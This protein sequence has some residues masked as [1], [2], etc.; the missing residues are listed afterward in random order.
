MAPEIETHSKSTDPDNSESPLSTRDSLKKRYLYKIFANIVGL[1]SNLVVASIVP[2]SLGPKS[3][4]DFNFVTHFFDQIMELVD[5]R[6]SVGA[7]IKIALRPR[8]SGLVVFYLY[9]S[10]L[11]SMLVF[12]FLGV[13]YLFSL[14]SFIWPGQLTKIIFLGCL[15]SV[16]VWLHGVLHKMCDAFGLTVEAEKVR[17]AQ[18]VISVVLILALFFLDLLTLKTFFIYY[19]GILVFLFIGFWWVLRGASGWPK[20]WILPWVEI[21][22]YAKEF[23]DYTL[24]LFTF[25]AFEAFVALMDR[26]VLQR[27]SGSEE[28]GYFGF[29]YQM[30]YLSFFFV[31]AMTP[32]LQRE[33]SVSYKEKDYARLTYLYKRYLPLHFAIATFFGAFVCFQAGAL[34]QIFAGQ[35]YQ[36]SFIPIMLLAFYSVYMSF[37]RVTSSLFFATGSNKSFRNL[38]L[39]VLA[40][41]L[42]LTWLLVGP[43]SFGGLEQGATGLAAKALIIYFVLINLQILLN[44]RIIKVRFRYFFFHQLICVGVFL[45]ASWSARE[46][47][48]SSLHSRPLYGF[49]ASGFLY[50]VMIMVLINAFPGIIGLHRLDIRSLL[51][52]LFPLGRK[53][54]SPVGINPPTQNDI[55]S[56]DLRLGQVSTAVKTRL[57][58]L[59][60]RSSIHTVRWVNALAERGHKVHLVTMHMGGDPLHPEVSVHELRVGAP[61]G[62]FF[63]VWKLRRILKKIQPDILHAHYITGYGTLGSLSGFQPRILS[64]WGSDIF[65]FPVFSLV[66]EWLV[67]LNLRKSR[68][69]C[70]TSST[71]ARQTIAIDPDVKSKIIVTPFGVDLNRFFP[72]ALPRR[73]DGFIT[74]GTVKALDFKYGVDILLRAF[75]ETINV[76]E[77]TS[78]D[79]STKLRLRIVGGGPLADALKELAVDLGIAN[80]VHF[81]GVVPHAE[82]PNELRKMD[83]YVAVSREDSESFGVAIVEASACGLPV[84]VSDAGGLPEV[85]DHGVTGFVVPRNS[86]VQLANC[87][88]ELINSESLCRKFGENG[89][90]KVKELY[91]WSDN[92]TQME[93]IY[94]I[95]VN[96]EAVDRNQKHDS[97]I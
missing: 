45:L 23:Y 94:T 17:V 46:L 66:N 91:D 52:G 85:V 89:V 40:M 26:W 78:I 30:G 11:V 57:V 90:A 75:A 64:V 41:G 6:S 61:W 53:F 84:V 5:G 76:L 38:G 95:I 33:F 25:F 15:W 32:L 65:S 14:E 56:V 4:G 10:F 60:A 77:R 93:K 28:Q 62:Y 47:V 19:I 88:L 24:P 18:K 72:S 13:A 8:E 16:L 68:W 79:L 97:R 49:V 55:S 29:A 86:P 12:G 83:I 36:P 31:G 92:V 82:V 20:S 73:A 42:I 74:I 71:M 43:A 48:P 50:T 1:L 39:T 2:R 35:A 59:S 69:I 22:S 70:S 58:I 34:I 96:D 81:V 63:N 7:I 3:Y 51:G 37:G 9:F 54:E 21:K 44:T 87:L 67:K 27:Y 80:Q